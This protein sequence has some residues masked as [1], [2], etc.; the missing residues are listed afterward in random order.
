MR[1]IILLIIENKYFWLAFTLINYTFFEMVAIKLNRPAYFNTT[2]CSVIVISLSLKILG[3][4]YETYL[5]KLLILQFLLSLT[6]IAFAIPLYENTKIILENWRPIFA[7]LII[8]NIM[9]YIPTI[10]MIKVL[11][12]KLEIIAPLMGKSTTSPVNMAIAEIT[13]SNISLAAIFSMSTGIIIAIIGPII[14]NLLRIK[15]RQIRGYSI[16]FAGHGVGCAQMVSEG[17]VAISF[18]VL[19]LILNGILTALTLPTILSLF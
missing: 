13:N 12:L 11:N 15:N 4:S 18:A 7:T 3:I 19:G 14:L 5:Q 2:L 10:I 17:E 16:G 1:D 6:I 8:A 9:S